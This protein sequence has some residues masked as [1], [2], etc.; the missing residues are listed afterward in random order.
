VIPAATFRMGSPKNELHRIHDE[1]PQKDISVP[2]FALSRFE[3]TWDEWTTCEEAGTCEALAADADA[4]WG[5]G[6]RP[7]IN[8]VWT[9]VIAYPEYLSEKTGATYRLPSE[10]EWEYAARAGTQTTFSYGETVSTDQANYDGNMAYGSGVKGVYREQTLPVGSFAAN[11]F[12]LFDMNGNVEEQVE[13]C[14]TSSLDATPTDGSSNAAPDCGKRVAR[15]GGWDSAPRVLRSSVRIETYNVYRENYRGFRI[16][17][18][19]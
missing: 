5:K 4:G 16:A 6:R 7:V 11:P 10:S 2:R 18:Q 9:E 14:F 3:T 12:G 19:L 1:G 15:G 8:L 17:R 13:D